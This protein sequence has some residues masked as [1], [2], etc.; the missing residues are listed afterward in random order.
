[1]DAA[2]EEELKWMRKQFICHI[3]S[4]FSLW[5]TPLLT[6]GAIFGVYMFIGQEVTAKS[7]FTTL[8]TLM[9]LEVSDD[10]EW[11]T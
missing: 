3:S 8:S 10:F 5:I 2:R 1:M 11:K 9:V 6:T 7:A 4:I